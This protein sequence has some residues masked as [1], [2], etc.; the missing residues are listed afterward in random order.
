MLAFAIEPFKVY[1][2]P[3]IYQVQESDTFKFEFPVYFTKADLLFIYC[4][5]QS[6]ELIDKVELS[7]YLSDNER[8]TMDIYKILPVIKDVFGPEQKT[9]LELFDDEDG[10]AEE[11]VF[12]NIILKDYTEENME[13]FIKLNGW[14]IQN[15]Y[16]HRYSLNI[17]IG[18]E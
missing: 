18:F 5:K 10:G 9:T 4:S 6:C 8:V 12:L 2:D 1:E 11:E 13:K 15:I 7:R 16:Q 3:L 17:N 14:F